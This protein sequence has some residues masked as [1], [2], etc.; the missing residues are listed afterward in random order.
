[1]KATLRI[2]IWLNLVLLGSLVFVLGNRRKEEA[3]LPPASTETQSTAPMEVAS[4]PIPP[5]PAK[6]EVEPFR[7][8]QL[9]SATSY[10]VYVANLRAIGCPETTVG[11]IVRGDTSRAFAWERNQLGLGESGNGP[12][13]PARERQLVAI[14]LGEP[15]AAGTPEITAPLQSAENQPPQTSG[16]GAATTSA[17]SQRAGVAARTNP[18]FLQDVN[19]NALGFDAGQQLAIAQVRQQF[20]NEVSSLNQNPGA[21]ATQNSVSAGSGNP[22]DPQRWQAAM[23][24]ADDTLRGSLGTDGYNAYLQQQYFNWYQ[25]QVAGN[26]GVGNL[27][28][29]AGVYAVSQ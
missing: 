19:W 8:R 2:S 26:N 15:P 21:P 14:L 24:N 25:P 17:R 28:I 22:A 7:W 1:M 9:V 27:T 11:D 29:D 20:V 4:L 16:G 5:A 18:L 13:S 23:Q 10:Q 12:W 6:V 3:A